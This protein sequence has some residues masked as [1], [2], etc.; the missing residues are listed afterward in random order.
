MP[1]LSQKAARVLL[2]RIKGAHGL[3]GEVKIAAFTNRPEDIAAYG[4]LTDCKG[5]R[6]I[7]ITAL[8]SA[9]GGTL[10]A[11][12]RGVSSRNEA[13][14]LR[15]LELFVCR[16]A[17]PAPET[18]E[19]YHSDLIGLDA[20]SPQGKAAGK[21]IAVHNFGAGDLLE[22]RINGE[23]QSMLIPFDAAHVPNVDI[24]AGRVTVIKPVYEADESAEE[25]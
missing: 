22:V 9:A 18:D 2:G 25:A 8:R 6:Q 23:K 10:V 7:D 4:P 17:L 16:E 20:I 1:P 11:R 15:G 3:N 13:E 14:K 19:Y 24:A 12:I 21:I 5:A